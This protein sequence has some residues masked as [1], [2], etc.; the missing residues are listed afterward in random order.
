MVDLVV[1]VCV[2]E[3]TTKKKVVNFFVF[4]QYFLLEPSLVINSA[5]DCLI[6][7]KIWIECKRV[8]AKCSKSKAQ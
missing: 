3:A 8:T 7:L 2:L 4:P 5:V 6:S 1:L